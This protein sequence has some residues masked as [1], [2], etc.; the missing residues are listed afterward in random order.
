MRIVRYLKNSKIAVVLIVCLLIVQAFTDLA[1]PNY[2]SQIVDVGIQQS[3]VEHAATE[4]MTARTHDLVAMMLPEGDEKT[5]DA[6]YAKTDQG[7]YKL[8]AQ[9]EKEQAELDRMVSLPLVAIHYSHQVPDL[10]LDQAL[11]AYQAGAVQKQQILDMLDKAKDRW[12][13]WG[14]PSST[15][16]PSRPRAPSTSSSATTCPIS[17]CATSCASA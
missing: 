16:R 13:T 15:S 7:T 8:N 12:A 4:E 6:A 10:D 17:R 3:G 14:I 9:G 5:F 1:L 2:T 11:Q